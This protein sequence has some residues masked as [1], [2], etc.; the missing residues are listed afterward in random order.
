MART[1]RS[2]LP[3]QT[4]ASASGSIEERLSQ[5]AQ[6]ISRKSDIASTPAFAAVVLIAPDG[7]RWLVSVD[8]AGAL[9]TSQVTA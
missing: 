2:Y 9:S 5:L 7:G 3:A 4:I 8:S 1:A 6:E